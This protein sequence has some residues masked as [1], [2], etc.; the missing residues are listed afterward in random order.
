MRC[1]HTC[2]RH[3]HKR[4]LT[5]IGHLLG[6]TRLLL[7]RVAVRRHVVR[8]VG[9]HSH[10]R[11]G[12]GVVHHLLRHGARYGCS[13]GSRCLLLLL[14]AVRRGVLRLT[15]ADRLRGCRLVRWGSAV[16][17]VRHGRGRLQVQ[18]VMGRIRVVD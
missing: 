10:M 1:H 3:D 2:P 6:T 4:V 9:D 17:G 8:Q 11:S 14:L 7:L 13:H 12:A 15:A 5:S 16:V 18:L